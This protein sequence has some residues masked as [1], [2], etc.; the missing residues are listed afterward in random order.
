MGY[1]IKHPKFGYGN[2]A[3]AIPAGTTAERPSAGEE[4]SGQ[5]RFNTSTGKMEYWD[6]TEYDTITQHGITVIDVENNH[7]GDG[8]TV[9]FTMNQTHTTPEE[10][11]V[12]VG[13]V[14]QIPT[15]NYSVS[16]TTITFTTA[17]PNSEPITLIHNLNSTV[18]L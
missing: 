17:P 10:V 14:Y 1:H 11:M 7:T 15:V 2:V 6:G 4:E 18:V 16:G 13:G 3:I 9:A 8:A 12:F 5:L